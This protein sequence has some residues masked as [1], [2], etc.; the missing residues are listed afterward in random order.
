VFIET[1]DGFSATDIVDATARVRHFQPR[2]GDLQSPSASN[3]SNGRRLQTA[4][5]DAG[6]TSRVEIEAE[7]AAPTVLV[8]AQ[9]FY[10]SWRAT[11]NNESAPVLR[12]NHAFQAIP[13]PAGKS[14]V[15][16]DYVDWPF[17]IGAAISLATLLGCLLLLRRHTPPA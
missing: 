12:A 4:G 1:Q 15:R 7:A 11:V 10:P 13:I 8:L 2:A 5:T 17:R 9:N 6:A 16:L 3:D 14:I